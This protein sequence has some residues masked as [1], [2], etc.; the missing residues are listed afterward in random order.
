MS[1]RQKY[2]IIQDNKKFSFDLMCDNTLNN[3]L[4]QYCSTLEVP[5]VII[6]NTLPT[7]VK[8]LEILL[9]EKNNSK[10]KI[11]TPIILDK[12]N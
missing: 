11:S 7:N 9:T 10:V 5:D 4:Y 2:G 8:L 3:F 1:F 6:L 12:N